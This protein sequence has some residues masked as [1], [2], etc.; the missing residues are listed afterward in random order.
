MLMT[1]YRYFLLNLTRKYYLMLLTL[2]T[3]IL[4]FTFQTKKTHFPFSRRNTE[5]DNNRFSTAPMIPLTAFSV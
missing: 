2:F 3:L 1:Y 4:K 5:N